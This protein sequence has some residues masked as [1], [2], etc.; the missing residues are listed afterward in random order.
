M[1]KTFDCVSLKNELQEKLF[2]EINAPTEE[3]YIKK[4]KKS[5][6]NSKWIKS[7]IESKKHLISTKS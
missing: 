6:D 4:L 5:I 1:N 2:N 7:I 3:E